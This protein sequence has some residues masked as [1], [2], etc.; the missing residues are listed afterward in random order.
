MSLWASAVPERRSALLRLREVE[1]SY[2]AFHIT[3]DPES[4]TQFVHRCRDRGVTAKELV[5]GLRK[6][7][8]VR[9]RFALL[10]TL[11]DYPLAEIDEAPR[12]ALIK[13]LTEVYRSD[14]SSA[15]HGATGWLLR[16]WGF[17]EE[18]T[19]VDHTPL[20]F[21][22][23]GKRE[24]YVVQISPKPAGGRGLQSGIVDGDQTVDEAIY[25]TFVVFPPGEYLMGSPEDQAER[26]PDE[27]LHRVELTRPLAVSTHEVT[28]EQYKA[29]DGSARHDICERQFGKRLTSTEPASGVNW[30]EAVAYCRWLT[31][32]SGLVGSG[33]ML[34]RSG[35]AAERR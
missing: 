12:D 13:E 23:T 9:S 33:P 20:P 14:P 26:Q 10:L 30:F 3:D 34:R 4:L 32:R 18:V 8:D 11:G 2:V 29:F 35:V 16:K 7:T 21:D 24:W 25:F 22:E 19:T 28:W 6:A 1:K 31:A 27:H 5:D 15:I 17:E